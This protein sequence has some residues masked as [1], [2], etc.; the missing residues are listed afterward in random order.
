MIT[1][2]TNLSE[3]GLIKDVQPHALPPGAFSDASNVRFVDGEARRVKGNALW[4]SLNNEGYFVMP[5][6]YADNVYWVTA[7]ANNINV[8]ID[9]DAT[10][11]TPAAGIN[12]YVVPPW[13]GVIFNGILVMNNGVDAPVYWVNTLTEAKTL[14]GW[15]STWSA[16]VIRSFKN[17]LV[18]FNLTESG[19][20]FPTKYRWSAFADPG[21]L[22]S[23]WDETDPTIAA[24][25][26]LLDAT[27]SAI[28][29]AEPLGD[30]LIA[31]TRDSA[32]VLSFI[33]GAF[34]LQERPLLKRQGC[35]ALNCVK[36]WDRKHFVV[37]D[38]DVYI[39]D[40]QTPQSILKGRMYDRIFPNICCDNFQGSFVTTNWRD[41]E[42]WF[43]FP[44]SG[45]SRP[46]VAAMWN[47]RS[48]TWSVRELD[49]AAHIAY[50]RLPSDAPTVDNAA[51]KQ[52][53]SIQDQGGG[54]T[55]STTLQPSGSLTPSDGSYAMYVIETTYQASG[56]DMTCTIERTGL[57][58]EA[59]D[60]VWFLRAAYPLMESGP[61][62]FY[63]GSQDSPNQ[64]PTW[65]GPYT[66]TPEGTE[67]KIDLRVTGRYL[68]W[69]ATLDADGACAITGMRFDVVKVGN[70]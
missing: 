55:P 17:M 4:N 45:S 30:Y 56:S 18:A 63:F 16:R 2:I 51:D 43:C 35:L 24:G 13:N 28:V 49:E 38:G 54:L 7:G 68:A 11:I 50:G 10:D 20:N 12:G 39:H 19:T 33:G 64:T 31:Y 52:L 58:P 60:G 53:V 42:M 14:I 70:R 32:H 47:W 62:D 27:Q 67:D 65:E 29:A 40:G 34:T 36:E 59:G 1:S 22:P 26:D 9:G 66:F 44:E 5:Y 61:A 8:W 21:S 46:N 48:N 69:K 6:E 25:S 41:D 15:T 3:F 23:S 57:Q 37:R